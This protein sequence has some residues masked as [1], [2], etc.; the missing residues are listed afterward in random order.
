MDRAASAA[1]ANVNFL[2]FGREQALQRALEDVMSFSGEE[3]TESQIIQ[4]REN[5][6]AW[7]EFPP[8][9]LTLEVL[10]Q[11]TFLD[12]E[13]LVDGSWV[14]QIENWPHRD[15]VRNYWDDN[16]NLPDGSKDNLDITAEHILRHSYDPNNIEEYHWRGLV[17]GN[18]R[19]ERPYTQSYFKGVWCGYW[20]VIVLSEAR[21]HW[22]NKLLEGW[23]MKFMQHPQWGVSSITT[24]YIM[25][26][27]GT[28]LIL[29]QAYRD[30]LYKVERH[31][32]QRRCW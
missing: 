8:S 30:I 14:D 11:T 26:S 17:V 5:F 31:G 22:G 9:G 20:T 15:G 16:T 24:P 28:K 21:N 27:L 2:G 7:L 4:I 19:V 13:N 1:V 10:S 18:I 3:P 23:I 29:Y 32:W 6:S 12:T 25:M